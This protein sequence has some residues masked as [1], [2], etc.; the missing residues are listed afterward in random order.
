MS[1]NLPRVIASTFDQSDWLKLLGIAGAMVVLYLIAKRLGR[2]DEAVPPPMNT[3][4]ST[5]L[6][7]GHTDLAES[8][9]TQDGEKE[10]DPNSPNY[11]EQPITAE[12]EV[13][14]R[15]IE[16]RDW[17]FAEFEIEAGP[18][19]RDSFSGELSVSLFDNSTSHAWNQVYFVATPAGLEK[20]LRDNKSSFM[21]L[22]Q[23]LVM[24]RYNINQLRKAVLD[25][26]GAMEE[27]RGDVPADASDA[28][29]EGQPG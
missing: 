3:P 9:A 26:L 12:E 1:L 25:D 14:P 8:Q 15:N 21:F 5:Q 4:A 18:P 22:P 24:N 23:T 27:E 20:M 16:I 11:E 2:S 29:S 28:A 13:Q 7:S 19:N 17:N 6:S 10:D